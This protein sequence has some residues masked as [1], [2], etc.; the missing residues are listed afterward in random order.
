MLTLLGSLFSKRRHGRGWFYCSP[1]PHSQSHPPAKS[2][3][4]PR[5]DRGHIS[6]EVRRIPTPLARSSAKAKLPSLR[7]Q[8]PALGIL[9]RNA[10]TR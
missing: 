2:D 9:G 3:I 4:L 10:A 1:P 5:S 8:P 6:Q 7:T